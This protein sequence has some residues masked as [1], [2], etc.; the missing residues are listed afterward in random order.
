MR[1][2]ISQ[3]DDCK[4][5]TTN[6]ICNAHTKD[7][8]PLHNHWRIHAIAQ[9]LRLQWNVAAPTHL[10][11]LTKYLPRNTVDRKLDAPLMHGR[12]LRIRACSGAPTSNRDTL[13]CGLNILALIIL[14]FNVLVSSFWFY[15]F[16]FTAL[17]FIIVWFYRFSFICSRGSCAYPT[18]HPVV[19]IK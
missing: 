16:A 3:L 10:A 5:L 4:L 18:T 2:S 6:N 14:V 13:F 19:A 17:A 7:T 1:S 9:N 12:S 8:Q 11:S 15:R